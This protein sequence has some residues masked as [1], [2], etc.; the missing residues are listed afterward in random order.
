M[1]ACGE[2]ATCGYRRAAW[3]RRR[4]NGLVVNLKPVLCVLRFKFSFPVPAAP[5]QGL[6][7][8]LIRI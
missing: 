1:S 2:K 6:Q 8:F 7:F 5:N 3:L 4:P